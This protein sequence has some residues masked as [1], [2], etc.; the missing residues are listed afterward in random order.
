MKF[1]L[2]IIYFM[3]FMSTH[4]YAYGNRW[5]EIKKDNCASYYIDKNSVVK[6]KAT[7]VN[8]WVKI[9]KAVTYINDSTSGHCLL[10]YN[11]NCK[12]YTY[13]EID[14]LIYDGNDNLINK[15]DL[16]I[17]NENKILPES[18]MDFYYGY[19]CNEK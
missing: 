15:S 14:M 5:V 11:I 17:H 8:F 7:S 13:M 10:N 3:L 6:S 1:I 2:C 4:S 12:N 16:I 9:K 18:M 19:I